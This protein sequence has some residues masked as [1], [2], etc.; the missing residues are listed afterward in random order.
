MISEMADNKFRCRSNSLQGFEVGLY[1]S[2]GL[3]GRYSI[4][5]V[6]VRR[7]LLRFGSSG[8]IFGARTLEAV[9]R[10]VSQSEA[11]TTVG[12]S[13]LTDYNIRITNTYFKGHLN[14]YATVYIT[15]DLE[16]WANA[17]GLGTGHL[18]LSRLVA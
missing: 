6:C 4:Y 16:A 8:W 9:Y 7:N 13:L 17:K 15:H 3:R 5:T 14:L 1:R 12:T 2:G 10:L 11:R 18:S